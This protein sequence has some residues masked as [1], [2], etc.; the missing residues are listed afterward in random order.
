MRRQVFKTIY[1]KYIAQLEQ[2]R[3]RCFHPL[4]WKNSKT[5]M[6]GPAVFVIEV[7][8]L[9]F[10]KSSDSYVFWSFVILYF[11]QC[12]IYLLSIASLWTV[13]GTVLSFIERFLFVNQDC[14][15]VQRC[16]NPDLVA[17]QGITMDGWSRRI[18]EF[19]PS[20]MLE[21][22]ISTLTYLFTI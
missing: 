7:L 6:Y 17:L 11:I 9:L 12:N 22:V 2:S 1:Y 19:V 5:H 3:L 13:F 4:L 18:L 20:R 21:D 10:E 16:P 8:S 14:C 15:Q